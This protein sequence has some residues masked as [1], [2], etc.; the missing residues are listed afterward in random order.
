MYTYIYIYILL[1]NIGLINS[2][3]T[4]NRDRVDSTAVSNPSGSNISAGNQIFRQRGFHGFAL[5]FYEH[6]N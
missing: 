4:E 6:A 2:M 3:Y 5:S 1:A